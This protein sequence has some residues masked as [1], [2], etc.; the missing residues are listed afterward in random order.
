MSSQMARRVGKAEVLHLKHR[1]QALQN[2][3]P[4]QDYSMDFI[5]GSITLRTNAAFGRKLNHTSGFGMF[6]PVTAEDLDSV[7]RIYEATGLPPVLDMST[8]ADPSAFDLLR[9]RY[10]V[11]GSVFHYHLSLINFEPPASAT[12]STVEVY[13]SSDNDA[14]FLEAS[15]EG[16]RSGGRDPELLKIL[17]ANA[18]ARSDTRLFFAM[19]EGELVGTAGMAVFDVD[20]CQVANLYVDSTLPAFRGKGVHRALLLARLEAAKNSG[21]D[22]ALTAA[23]QSSGSARNIEKV[24]FE[25]AYD[26][27]IF[28]KRC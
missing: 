20:G 8:S 6:G 4:E 2:C 13:E 16:F 1:L 15:V 22:L 24:G 19:L 9:D 28:V 26:C 23:R 17:A 5:A 27:N 7:E 18:V 10:E 25:K 3:Y 21:C 11:T 14:A 12:C